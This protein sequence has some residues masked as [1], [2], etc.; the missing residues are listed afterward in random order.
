MEAQMK[1][2]GVRARRSTTRRTERTEDDGSKQSSELFSIDS[3]LVPLASLDR[4]HASLAPS[5]SDRLILRFKLTL[6]S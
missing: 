2:S 6:P 3:V 1:Q 4:L 5:A